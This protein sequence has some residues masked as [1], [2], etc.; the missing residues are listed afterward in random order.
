M[1]FPAPKPTRTKREFK[2]PAPAE[3]VPLEDY[4]QMRI[5]GWLLER[6]IWHT[7]IVPDRKICKRLGYQP[8]VQDVLIFDRPPVCERGLLYVGCAVEVKRV[9]GGTLSPEQ[10]IWRDALKERGW[11][12][13]VAHGYD[14]FVTSMNALGWK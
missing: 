10:K 8:G 1:I 13:C 3:K 5:I 12:V 11:A 4:E 7:A 9:K 2:R 6:K 14:E